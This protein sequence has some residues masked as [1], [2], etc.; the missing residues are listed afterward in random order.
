MSENERFDPSYDSDESRKSRIE[1][2]ESC[3]GKFESEMQIVGE[4]IRRLLNATDI[5]DE[6]AARY[7]LMQKHHWTPAQCR[8]MSIID[9]LF[10]L[11]YEELDRL[12][13]REL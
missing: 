8:E 2:A 6:D 10:A 4:K 12:P 5:S 7:Y 9:L 11:E 13:G 1:T 3:A